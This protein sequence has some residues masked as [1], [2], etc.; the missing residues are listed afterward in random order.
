L[1]IS[2]T[3]PGNVMQLFPFIPRFKVIVERVRWG[4]FRLSNV[5]VCWHPVEV[6]LRPARAWIDTNREPK[7]PAT[8]LE[9]QGRTS[10]T[11]S[12][13]RPIP[14]PG[15]SLEKAKPNAAKTRKAGTNISTRSHPITTEWLRTLYVL[16]IRLVPAF[17]RLLLNSEAVSLRYIAGR[18]L[19]GSRRRRTVCGR[20]VR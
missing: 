2:P 13:G 7:T 14:C 18:S 1:V 19:I 15:A 16:N 5:G 8:T 20:K 12:C 9:Q 10:L 17:Y 4:Q 3:K 6:K 11:S